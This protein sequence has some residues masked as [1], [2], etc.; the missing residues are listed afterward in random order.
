MQEDDNRPGAGFNSSRALGE[1]A[2]SGGL[3]FRFDFDF[4]L[5]RLDIATQLKDPAKVPGE[6]WFWEPKTEYGEF[7]RSV[8]GNPDYTFRPQV[9][10]NFGIGYPF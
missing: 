7:V 1:L 2:F 3:G 9:G 4:F 10:I 6:R 5:V 8:T